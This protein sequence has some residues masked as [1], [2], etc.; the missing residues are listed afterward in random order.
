MTKGLEGPDIEDIDDV[1]DATAV[2]DLPKDYLSHSQVNLWFLCGH[3]YYLQYVMGESRPA[4]SNL[5]HGRTVHSAVEVL[6]NYKIHN[7]GAMPPRELAQDTITD[8]LSS[9][10]AKDIEVWDPKIPNAEAMEETART[11]TD[12]YYDERLP[13]TR[14]RA[15]ELKLETLIR[16]SIKILGY[17]DLIEDSPM[18]RTPGQPVTDVKDIRPTDFV[19]DLKNT[20]KTY[21][22]NRVA[23][24]LQ[25]TL[26]SAVTGA[27][28]VAFD[29]LVQT[30][31]PKFVRQESWRPQAEREHAF[32]VVED[33]AAAISAGVFP[34]TDPES[35]MCTEKWCPFWKQCR[36]RTR[37]YHPVQG[38]S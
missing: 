29:L 33:V 9:D 35:W 34:K 27:E 26:Y 16:G 5:V 31:K 18:A 10:E 37:T 2:Y 21:G 17:A 13:S 15:T 24:S 14:P 7:Q 1:E 38:A 32:D 20:S 22:K 19:T 6:N 12:I 3:R 4:S 23:D 11:M 36:G 25:L 8:E 28:N 30:K